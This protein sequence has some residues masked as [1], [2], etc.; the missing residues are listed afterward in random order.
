MAYN[1]G[2]TKAATANQYLNPGIYKLK[3]TDVTKDKFPKGSP[4]VGIKFENED[5]L[6]FVEKFGFGSDKASEVSTSRLQYIHLGFFGKECDKEFKSLDDL[7]T[8]FGKALTGGKKTIVKT[9]VVGGNE[10]GNNVFACLPYA[11][12]ILED[13]NDAELGEFDPGSKEYK[14]V[15]KKN[16][17]VS[18]V[19]DKENGLLNDSD[20]EE[21]GTKSKSKSAEPKAKAASKGKPAVEEKEEDDADDDDDMPW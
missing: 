1:F 6:S 21:I 17:T 20:D 14:K 3:V 7:A 13:D 9:I 18:E 11:G 5:G 15:V 12:F 19:A 8:Y 4:Y 10:S 2:K 16:T